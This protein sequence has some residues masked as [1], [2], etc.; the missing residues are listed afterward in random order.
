MA[1][2][3]VL[4]VI[5][6]FVLAAFLP[7]WWAQRVGSIVDGSFTT[8]TG[9][10]LALGIGCTVVSLLLLVL[11]WPARQWRGGRYWVIGFIVLAVIVSI[12]NL[13]TLSIVVGD[14]SAAHAGERILDVAAPA[15]RGATLTGVIIGAV[16]CGVVFFLGFRYRRGRAVATPVATPDPRTP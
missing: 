4:V 1:V 15:F 6:Y 5:T 9:Y 10:G 16:V 14:G 11:A 13:L 7:R 8:G 2:L 3:V 12:P